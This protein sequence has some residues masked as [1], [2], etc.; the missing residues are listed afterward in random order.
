MRTPFKRALVAMA[1]VFLLFAQ[2]W[3]QEADRLFR[4]RKYAEAARVLDAGVHNHPGDFAA[5]MLLG[6]CRQQ[7]G[8]LGKAEASFLA[9]AKLQPKNAKAR[10]ALARLWFLMGRFEQ[11][12]AAADQALTLGERPENVHHLRGRIEEERGRLAPALEE[13]RRAIASDRSMVPAL[14]GEASVLYKLSRYEEARASAE[15]ALKLDTGNEEA[16]RV[17]KQA[18]EAHHA[19]TQDAA[20]AVRFVQKAGIDFKLDHFP[21]AEKHLI[22]TMAGGLAVFDF[23]DDGRQDIFFANGAE[24]PSLKKTG[25]RFWNRMYRNLG[26]WRFED[27]TEAQGLQGEGFSMGAVAGD[28]DGDGRI[29]LFVPG[30]R[31]NLLYRNTTGGFVEVSKKAGIRDEAWSVGAAWVDYNRD[32]LL[33]LFVVNYLDW[34]A[35]AEKY[36]GDRAKG[37]RVYCHPREYRGLP[38][39]LYR[40]RGD[41]TFEDVSEASGVLRHVGKGMSAAVL[42][43]D[44]DGWPDVFVTNDSAPN[45]LFRNQ[46]DGTFEEAALKFGVA[47]NEQGSAVSSM[48]VDARDYNN[49]GLPDLIVTAL[50]GENFPLFR[51]LG[52]GSFRDATYPSRLGLAAARRSGWGV[53]M[54]DLNNDGWKDLFTANSHVTDN[55]EAIRSE[56]YLEPSSVFLNRG[57]V[58]VGVQEIGPAAAHRG[59]VVADLDNDGRLDAV[60]TVLGGRPEIWRNETDGG[61]WVNVRLVGRSVGARVR[62]GSQW[63]ERT[64]AVGY[65]S[66]NL[67]VLHFGLG[68]LTEVPEVAVYWP[69][70]GV[71]VVRDVK[72]GQTLVIRQ[73]AR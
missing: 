5:H 26:N 56:R 49:D 16:R 70:G 12:L 50:V 38:N 10:F 3:R 35:D 6:L 11:A 42:D 54:A 65:A 8:E 66:S 62:V 14:S 43:A 39:R 34:S 30:V 17:L 46:R 36:C 2:S 4:E 1:G 33:D 41:G 53:A 63:Q 64:A 15:A 72:A 19:R 69:G 32:G 73:S 61:N 58:F 9:A 37:V 20:Q 31:R 24:I 25:P 18:T 48:G 60:I 71:D 13:Y 59:V 57:G 67:D 52:N 23:D 21:T 29:D 40:N 22:S 47:F 45:F 55:I 44:G 7:L 68:A 27:V 28:F 51:N